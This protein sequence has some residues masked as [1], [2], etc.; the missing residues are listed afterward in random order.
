MRIHLRQIRFRQLRQFQRLPQTNALQLPQRQRSP[1]TQQQPPA[2]RNIRAVRQKQRE[3]CAAGKDEL[4][5][6]CKRYFGQLDVLP[7]PLV[8]VEF[9]KG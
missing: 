1:G 6:S 7:L 9:G 3:V 5:R 8:G 4:H 2:C